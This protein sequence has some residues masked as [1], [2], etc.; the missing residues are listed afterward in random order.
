M[1]KMWLQ[2]KRIYESLFLY[3]FPFGG[4]VKQINFQKFISKKLK[5]KKYNKNFLRILI[6]AGTQNLTLIY[7]SFQLCEEMSVYEYNY[8]HL[9][10]QKCKFF[11]LQFNTLTQSN[12]TDFFP[13]YFFPIE[14]CVQSFCPYSQDYFMC[15][16]YFLLLR[17]KCVIVCEQYTYICMIQYFQD[18]C[19]KA[20]TI[21]QLKK[22][23]LILW[24]KNLYF[25]GKKYEKKKNELR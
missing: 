12:M 25:S 18:S 24:G 20:N 11:L 8:F 13:F 9:I 22:V 6:Q 15:K 10:K 5:E 3:F 14:S 1:S 7:T 23:E 17:D 16:L 19:L 4:Y 21:Q 2:K